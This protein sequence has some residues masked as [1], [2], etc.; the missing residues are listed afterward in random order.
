MKDKLLNIINNKISSYY[1][2]FSLEICEEIGSKKAEILMMLMNQFEK[3]RVSKKKF[4]IYRI[5][6]Y[7]NNVKFIILYNQNTMVQKD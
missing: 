1:W 3:S 6:Y 4:L 5:K 7:I 2:N